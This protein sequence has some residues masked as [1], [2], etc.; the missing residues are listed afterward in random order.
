[1]QYFTFL[2]LTNSGVTD[3]DFSLRK[4]ERLR[5]LNLSFNSISRIECLPAGLEEL[6]LNGNLIDEVSIPV[7]KPVTTLTHLGVSYNKIK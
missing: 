5:S 2:N 1:M 3:M 7:N 4:F 6:Y